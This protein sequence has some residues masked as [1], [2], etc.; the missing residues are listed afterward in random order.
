MLMA[1]LTLDRE[2]RPL[3]SVHEEA[4][5]LV[6]ERL[7]TRRVEIEQTIFR[8]LRDGVPNPVS[9]EGYLRGVRETVSASVDYVLS[10]IETREGSAAPIPQTVLAQAQRA[11]CQGV[12]LDIILRRCV[13]G[14]MTLEDFIVQE[15]DRPAIWAEGGVRQV[16]AASAASLDR[17][18]VPITAAYREEIGRSAAAVRPMIGGKETY[19][20]HRIT[21]ENR[22][23]FASS[24]RGE[25]IPGMFAN[26]NASRPRECLLFLADHPGSSNREIAVGIGVVHPPQISRLLSILAR[27]GLLTKCSEGVGKRNAWWLTTRGKELSR[28]LRARS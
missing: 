4:W 17:L 18:I 22:A 16:L 19:H 15:A 25:G 5:S 26:P 3:I 27:D 28:T 7:R 12:G 6:T 23:A 2:T 10:G 9:D 1:G 21:L 14:Y 20:P 8:R 11:A 24:S 13:A